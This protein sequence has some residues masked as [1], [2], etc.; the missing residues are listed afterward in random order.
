MSSPQAIAA[1]ARGPL[2]YRSAASCR[3][4]TLHIKMPHVEPHELQPGFV[5]AVNASLAAH[6]TGVQVVGACVRR[7]CVELTLDLVERAGAAGTAGVLGG[8]HG[9]SSH[10]ALSS[11]VLSALGC[12]PSQP[13]KCRGAAAAVAQ[14]D[15]LVQCGG[16]CWALQWDPTVMQWQVQ[17]AAPGSGEHQQQQQWQEEATPSGNSSGGATDDAPSVFIFAPSAVLVL[18]GAA[19]ARITM[20]CIGDAA[21]QHAPPSASSPADVPPGALVAPGSP[22]GSAAP[23]RFLARGNGRSV[24]ARLLSVTPATPNTSPAG[25]SATP[26]PSPRHGGGAQAVL[27]TAPVH[28][29]EVEV[30]VA[31]L[32]AGRPRCSP[33]LVL[34]LELWRGARVADSA[35]VACLV[36]PGLVEELGQLQVAGGAEPGAVAAAVAT[37]SP[38]SSFS[39][40][41]PLVQLLDTRGDMEQLLADL[42]S[43]LDL[44]AHRGPGAQ[45]QGQ[46]AAG[47][48]PE[49]LSGQVRNL[50][51]DPRLQQCVEAG[52][53][54]L[55]QHFVSHGLVGLACWLHGDLARGG[56]RL[57]S[58]VPWAGEAGEQQ[59]GQ[60]GRG[61]LEP[62]DADAR[63]P[64]SLLHH[65][66]RSGRYDMVQAVLR[67]AA[68]VEAEV[69]GGPSGAA[70]R[71]WSCRCPGGLTPLHLLAADARSP[72]E[73]R[74]CSVEPPEGVP[75][76]CGGG[77]LLP[78]ALDALLRAVLRAWPD[79]VTVWNTARD[80]GGNTPAG[81][82]AALGG[83]DIQ[84]Q[85]A[86]QVGT[87]GAAPGARERRHRLL[88][89]V[90]PSPSDEHPV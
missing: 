83:Q 2:R 52:G 80:D 25:R 76:G 55:L 5:A 4:S 32:S 41:S 33:G 84:P 21:W 8:G 89:S 48:D 36:H 9:A 17:V 61:T 57:G 65:A 42:G 28:E 64:V 43:W 86:A 90:Q 26:T 70:L 31:A 3:R 60:A 30:D 69:P 24:P 63:P 14:P 51:A 44:A 49:D 46:G 54:A 67:W 75:A 27:T 82:W 73:S 62:A 15:V 6:G 13:G 23:L 87:C 47:A 81:L 66:V 40:S 34:R 74:L 59:Q 72:E 35:S 50:M 11:L 45:G 22:S 85:L 29:V 88:V 56:V 37:V 20:A 19:T 16:Q 77:A 7:G 79:A 68:E 1:V 18:P 78:G 10:V 53:R 38:F 71:A 58:L 39:S 12:P